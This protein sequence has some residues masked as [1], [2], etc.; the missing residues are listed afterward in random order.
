MRSQAYA[1]DYG[2]RTLK[3]TSWGERVDEINLYGKNS[4]STQAEAD[5][6]WG[7]ALAREGREW[8]A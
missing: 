5:H 7:A 1:A 4:P 6:L 2:G 3:L 8:T